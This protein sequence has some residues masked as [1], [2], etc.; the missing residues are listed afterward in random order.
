MSEWHD[1]GWSRGDTTVVDDVI[2]DSFTRHSASGTSVRTRDQLKD[3][4][5]Q[6]Q[7]ALHQPEITVHDRIV[8]GDRVWS[9]L[10]MRGCNLDTGERRT[11]DSL[12]IHRIEAGRIVE[13]WSLH[14]AAANWD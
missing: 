11:V 2:G 7:R 4:L 9:R 1:R 12:T 10:T 14:A 6:Y 8:D 13:V 3:D 5:R